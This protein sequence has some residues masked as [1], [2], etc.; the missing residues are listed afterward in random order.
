MTFMHKLSRRLALLKDAFPLAA[1]LLASCE[2]RRN[3]AGVD[4]ELRVL[5]LSPTNVALQPT[6]IVDFTVVGLDQNGDTVDF[7]VLW[8]VTSGTIVDTGTNGRGHYG[9]YRAGSDTG[10]VKVIAKGRSSVIAD[11]ASVLVTLASVGSPSPVASVTVSPAS[12]SVAG[13]ATVQLTATPKDSAGN[14]LSGRVVSWTSGDVSVAIVFPS[15]L[16]TGVAVGSATI[17]ATSEGQSGTS[18]ITVTEPQP[19]TTGSCLTQ[20]GPTITLSGARSPY[21]NRS[22]SSNTK[23]DARAASWTGSDNHAVRYGSG[24]NICWSG[25]RI[26]GTF[27]DGTSWSAY[28]DAYS[29]LIRGSPGTVIEGVRIHNYGDG[30]NFDDAGSEGW[31][32]RGNHLSYIHDDCLSNDFGNTGL[33]E[34][35]LFDGC[36]VG[37]SSRAYSG[38]ADNRS[39]VVTI[40]NNLWRL[41]H[42][43][44]SYN[45][46][47][48]HGRFWK[49]NSSDGSGTDPRLALHN[50]IFRMDER[51]VCCGNFLIPPAAY[52][53]SCSN[54]IMVWLGSGDFPEP[55]PSC[56]TLTRDKSVWDN[57]VADWLSRHPNLS[58]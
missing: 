5:Q 19:P 52:L 25:G 11:T 51:P 3:V 57:A 1:V 16:V 37:Y 38:V 53:A 33:L 10:R 32:V 26:T 2:M 4:A 7:A 46:T 55:I 14:P 47:P 44:T 6:Q 30:P 35:N 12:A 8:S 9:R 48:G 13:G 50:N 23:I 24:S 17:T 22:V 15:G 31:T 43:P 58:P 21:D 27:P 28:H 49:M 56:F 34:D 54:N 20:A 39:K 45:G 29:M 41:Q 18:A 40:R 42:M 36:Y